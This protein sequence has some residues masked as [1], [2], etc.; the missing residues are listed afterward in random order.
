MFVIIYRPPYSVVN[1]VR[2]TTFIDEFATYLTST[3]VEYQSVVYSGDFNLHMNKP[4]DPSVLAFTEVLDS[5]NLVQHVQCQ[6]HE[7]GN[8]LDL[9]ITKSND[10][11]SLSSPVDDYYV[12]DHSFIT[13]HITIPKPKCLINISR[14]RKLKN[15]DH[16]KFADDLAVVV[17]EAENVED[18]DSLATLYHD[19]LREVL[20]HHAPII[21]KRAT[22]KPTVPWFDDEANSLKRARRRAEK[23]WLHSRKESD[24]V[25]YRDATRVYLKYLK[26]SK[27][28]FITML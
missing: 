11:I 14:Y 15:I 16:S 8:T 12:S 7:L 20:D 25:A 22:I 3:L 17:K 21:K 19:R 27:F 26:T 1:P 2:A 5:C 13:T 6:T 18:V 24:K 10:I 4:N 28:F 23:R 9:I